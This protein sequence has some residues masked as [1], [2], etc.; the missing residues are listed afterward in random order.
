MITLFQ[1]ALQHNYPELTEAEPDSL[2]NIGN[3]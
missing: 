1:Q 2:F 3:M